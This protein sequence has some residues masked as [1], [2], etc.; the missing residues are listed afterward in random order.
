MI[1]AAPCLYDLMATFLWSWCTVIVWITAAT[2]RQDGHSPE[3]LGN[4]RT[5]GIKE[6]EEKIREIH[7]K[8]GENWNSLAN[9]LENADIAHFITIFCQ[10][11][12]VINVT[13]F[14]TNNKSEWGKNVS[15]E[16]VRE[17]TSWRK[18]PPC[19]KSNMIIWIKMAANQHI[20]LIKCKFVFEYFDNKYK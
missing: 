8:S 17:Y 12:R 4:Q 13:F 18:W 15:Q 6:I 19:Q 7:E 16:N 3:N 9:V 20:L 1:L 11:I 2:F 14:Y 10:R 5:V